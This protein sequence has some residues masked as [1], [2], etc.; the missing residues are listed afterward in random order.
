MLRPRRQE[1]FELFPLGAV[2]Q[3]LHV[4]LGQILEGRIEAESVV[5][6]E[7]IQNPAAPTIAAVAHR[8]RDK[9]SLVQGS[10]RIGHQQRRM[11]PHRRADAG[12]RWA[13]ARGV[14]ERELGLVHLAGDKPMPGAAETVVKLLVLAAELLRLHD[15]KAEQPV[16]E[17]QSVLQRSDDLLVDSGADDER[18]DH[19][20]DRMRLFFIEFDMVPQVAR[21][22]VDPRPP[23]AVDANLLEQILVILAVNLVDRR[24]HLDLRALWAGTADVPSSDAGCESRAPRRTTGSAASPSWRT[25]CAGSRRCRSSCRPSSGDW[26]RRFFDRWTR[27]ATNR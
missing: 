21:L 20:F 12:A 2:K 27:P 16:A 24:P 25:A 3:H 17:F 4:L 13:C 14:V 19:G 1:D 6:G 18:I 23:V 11:H 22:A 15:V 9:R 7:T 5:C 8:G 26:S 10:L